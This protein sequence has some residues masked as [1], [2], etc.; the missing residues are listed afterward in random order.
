MAKELANSYGKIIISKEV[1]ANLAG[2]AATECFGVVGMVSSRFFSDG[3]L[4]LL[5]KEALSKGV[6]IVLTQDSLTIR[7]NVVI[8]YGM[9]ISVVAK[10]VIE[11]ARYT[12]EKHT[13][14]KVDHI[15]VNIQAVRIV[16]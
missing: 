11:N 1:I 16:D 13:G 3:I 8:S 5:G 15:D 10:N 7:L 4:E 9:N 6:D 12:V 14:L 2:I